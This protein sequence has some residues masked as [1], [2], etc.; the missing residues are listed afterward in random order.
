MTTRLLAAAVVLLTAG[1]VAAQATSPMPADHR[2]VPGMVHDAPTASR[3]QPRETGQSA[4]AALAE[5]VA[6]LDA[7]PTTDW[8]RVDLERLRAHLVDMDLVTLRAT[9]TTRAIPGGFEATLAGDARTAAALQRVWRAHA[10]MLGQQGAVRVAVT[11]LPGGVRL[12]VVA[13]DTRAV[14]R[15][16]ALGAIGLL[17]EGAHHQAHH[18]MLARGA[19]PPGHGH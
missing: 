11:D 7:D 15:V 13:A 18:L 9:A 2:H 12:R 3:A 19:M 8:S 16:R 14:P 6:L 10:G 4:F 5:I 17:T 1:P